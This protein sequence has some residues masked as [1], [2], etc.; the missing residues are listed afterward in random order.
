MAWLAGP[1]SP[2][3]GRVEMDTI[4]YYNQNAASFYKRTIHA[5][6]SYAYQ[7]FIPHLSPQARILDAGCGVG[8]DAL[9]FKAQGFDVVA[10]DASIEM[11]KISSELLG[12]PT[13]HCLFQ[14]LLFENEFDAIWASASLLHVPYRELR[15]ILEKLHLALKPSGIFYASFKYGNSERIADNRFFSDLNE[16]TILSYLEGIFAP[17]EIWQVADTRSQNPSPNQTW[18]NVFCKSSRK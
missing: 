11:V 15:S 18:L 13:L 14:D 5:D 7:K 6:I 3:F 17:I 9:Y 16:K 4:D 1:L 10:L 2:F 12:T 8:R